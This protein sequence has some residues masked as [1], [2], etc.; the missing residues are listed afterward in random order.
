MSSLRK[1]DGTVAR[2]AGNLLS[3]MEPCSE[4]NRE[5]LA[6]WAVAM[7]RAIVVEVERTEFPQLA[8]AVGQ[9]S[10]NPT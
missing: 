8:D 9:R 1:Y 5:I 7:A 3:G 6:Q 4:T 2:I 10:E